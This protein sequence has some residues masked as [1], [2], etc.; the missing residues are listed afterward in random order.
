MSFLGRQNNAP[1][2][3]AENEAIDGRCVKVFA[4]VITFC[5]PYTLECDN[6]GSIYNDLQVN[7][8]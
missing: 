2:A 4:G 6:V 3:E 1:T 8:E 5:L 7:F